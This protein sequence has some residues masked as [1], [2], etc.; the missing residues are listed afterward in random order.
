MVT[1]EMAEMVDPA[2][3]VDESECDDQTDCFSSARVA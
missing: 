1:Q 3:I 2:T